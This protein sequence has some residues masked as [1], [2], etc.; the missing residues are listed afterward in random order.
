M[1]TPAPQTA[2]QTGTLNTDNS[3]HAALS[4]MI[5]L[6][7]NGNAVGGLQKIQISESREIKMIDEIGTDGHVDST[8]SRS[9][10]ITGSCE[11]IRLD[12]LRIAEAF[13]RG[14]LHVK[15]QRFP[16]TIEIFD[17]MRGSNLAVITTITNVWIEKIDYGYNVGDWVVSDNMSFKAEKISSYISSVGQIAAQ[18][19][20]LRQLPN[21]DWDIYEMAADIGN[22]NG[23]MDSPNLLSGPLAA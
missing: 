12:G 9:S 14:F 11:R 2:Y 23:A 18:T 20:S 15:S 21:V 19:G 5:V 1:V 8:P 6:K 16:F 10:D 4:T 22:R 13:S 7:V 3:T 17:M